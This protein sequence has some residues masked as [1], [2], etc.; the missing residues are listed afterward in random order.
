MNVQALIIMGVS[1]SGKTSVGEALAKELGW[2]FFDGDS[3]H[4]EANVKK[5]SAGIPLNDDDRKPWLERLHDLMK[6]QLEEGKSVII[7]CSALKE[8]YRHILRGNLNVRF[9]YL[10]GSFELI[11]ERMQKRKDHFMKAT[12]LESQFETLEVPKDAITVSIADPI[13]VIIQKVI[14]HLNARA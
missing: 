9:V 4:P 7:G 8:S 10:E 1:G 6:G 14:Q 12:M 11:M 13:E 5:M 2:P 3:F